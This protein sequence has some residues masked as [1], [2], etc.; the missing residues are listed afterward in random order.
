MKGETAIRRIQR[1]AI[2]R[3]ATKGVEKHSEV[4]GEIALFIERS[5]VGFCRGQAIKKILESRKSQG[6]KAEIDE[7][8]DAINYLTF[9]IQKLGG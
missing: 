4:A 6:V 8:L 5:N 9:A 7:L 1:A 2:Q 3:M